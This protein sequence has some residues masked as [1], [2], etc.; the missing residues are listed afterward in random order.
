M[1]DD[2]NLGMAGTGD[3]LELVAGVR[4]GDP[5]GRGGALPWS[6]RGAG[7]LDRAGDRL[8]LGSRILERLPGLRPALQIGGDDFVVQGTG[9]IVF[10]NKPTR[11]PEIIAAVA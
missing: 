5:L 1:T 2:F 4:R 9:R 7:I 3:A 11:R 10:R 8:D 6:L